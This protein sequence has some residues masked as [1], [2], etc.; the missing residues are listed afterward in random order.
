MTR[1]RE[2]SER[3]SQSVVTYCVQCILVANA[4]TN[5]QLKFKRQA[6]RNQRL[7]LKA[8]W[9]LILHAYSSDYRGSIGAVLDWYGVLAISSKN[10]WE[11][12]LLT[13]LA[14]PDSYWEIVINDFEGRAVGVS[15]VKFILISG[16][17]IQHSSYEKSALLDIVSEFQIYS[18][19][20][21]R[22]A[23]IAHGCF[24]D[25]WECLLKIDGFDRSGRVLSKLKIF[26]HLTLPW[27]III[28]IIMILIII[29]Y[30]T[31]SLLALI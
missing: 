28:I 15:N 14:I 8:T 3:L 29:W 1:L 20:I 5:W 25:I 6:T 18:N 2:R 16:Y 13:L 12:S 17:S 27:I 4:M 19:R 9:H 22:F 24:S 26:S 10:L 31:G 23:L 21:H 11:K 30:N 7:T